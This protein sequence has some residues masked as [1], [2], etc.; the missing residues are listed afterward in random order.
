MVRAHTQKGSPPVAATGPG[1]AD[2]NTD[3]SGGKVGTTPEV[4]P[5]TGPSRVGAPC[6][7]DIFRLSC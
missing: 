6:A 7:P 4:S 1:T 5:T 2:S 3:S